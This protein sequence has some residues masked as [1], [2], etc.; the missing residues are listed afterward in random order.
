M[1]KISIQAILVILVLGSCAE[2]KDSPSS[3]SDKTLTREGATIYLEKSS[4]HGDKSFDS[5]W[6]VTKTTLR[7]G[8]QDGVELI[9]LDNGKLTISII[10]T[11]GMGI[12]DVTMGDI[13]LGWDSPV[14]EV[15]H[16]SYVD[17]QPQQ[18]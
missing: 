4:S 11:R 1:N 12:L 14:K 16:P 2:K 13:R 9:T 6:S 17:Q 5:Q 7:G 15:V 18:Q 8:K 3:S 10:P